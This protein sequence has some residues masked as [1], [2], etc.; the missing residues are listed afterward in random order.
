MTTDLES[1]QINK[2]PPSFL[3]QTCHLLEYSL[4]VPLSDAGHPHAGSV[5][6]NKHQLIG[7]DTADDI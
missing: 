6:D 5:S 3:P 7:S 2:V 1:P 4:C